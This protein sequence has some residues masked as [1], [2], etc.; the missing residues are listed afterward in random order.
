MKTKDAFGISRIFLTGTNGGAVVV[1]PVDILSIEEVDGGSI[2]TLA[3]SGCKVELKV[4]Q[5]A[6]RVKQKTNNLSIKQENFHK[7][8][9]EEAKIQAQQNFFDQFPK[10]KAMFQSECAELGKKCNLKQ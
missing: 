5:T 6:G 3:K 10:T 8:I 2:V 1:N 4:K 9:E 7:Q